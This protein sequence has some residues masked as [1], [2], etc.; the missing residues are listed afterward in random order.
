MMKIPGWDGPICLVQ[1]VYIYSKNLSWKRI[2]IDVEGQSFYGRIVGTS[3]DIE[4]DIEDG[5]WKKF[6]MDLATTQKGE[7]ILRLR[8]GS[9]WDMVY[10]RSGDGITI[11]DKIENIEDLAYY[12][13][14]C[15]S[16]EE[17]RGN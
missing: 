11:E 6:P 1:G 17:D 3:E 9:T 12:L 8:D 5:I 2:Y 4:I 14:K 13:E 7:L 16:I 10:K 15:I